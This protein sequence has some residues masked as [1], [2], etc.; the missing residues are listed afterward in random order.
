M[1]TVLKFPDDIFSCHVILPT[2]LRFTAHDC[3][4]ATGVSESD[5][6]YD[7]EY[8]VKYNFLNILSSFRLV[9]YLKIIKLYLDTRFHFG[10]FKL[11]LLSL[12]IN[13]LVFCM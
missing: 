11:P 8:M 6:G 1:Y 12:I 2:T 9:A 7:D 3:D 4:P 5:Q 10:I 13:S